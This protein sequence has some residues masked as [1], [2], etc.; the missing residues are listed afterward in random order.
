[1]RRAAV[2]ASGGAIVALAAAGCGAN[3]AAQQRSTQ[4]HVHTTTRTARARTSPPPSAAEILQAALL[5]A[6]KPGYQAR[7]H[8]RIRVPQF[9]GDPATAVGSGSFDPV[10]DTGTLNLAVNPPGLLSLIGPLPTQALIVG[11]ALYLRVPPDLADLLGSSTEWL[12]GSVTALG[13]ADTVKPRVV[14]S[15]TARDATGR[16]AGQHARVTIDPATGLIRSLILA[17]Y[18]PALR[19]HIRVA[20]RFTGF[21]AVRPADAPPAAGVGDLASAFRQLVG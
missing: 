9:G 1:M 7:V 18:D 17:F 4:V 3:H 14:L 11:D 13:L 2:L 12:E 15:Q 5:T 20:L 16:V 21:R 10:S 6:G 8:I 19:A